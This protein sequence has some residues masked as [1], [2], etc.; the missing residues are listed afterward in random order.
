M[1]IPGMHYQ[2]ASWPK[3]KKW[4]WWALEAAVLDVRGGGQRRLACKRDFLDHK[5]ALGERAI[6]LLQQAQS[7]QPQPQQFGP[8][9]A[10]SWR[11]RP[12][13]EADACNCHGKSV[14]ELAQELLMALFG[15]Q[16]CTD[17]KYERLC[18]ALPEAAGPSAVDWGNFAHACQQ[19]LGELR[20]ALDVQGYK[21]QLGLDEAQGFA[22]PGR[23][24]RPGRPG[25][26]PAA[27]SEDQLR[28]LRCMDMALNR[29]RD[30]IDRW[31]PAGSAAAAGLAVVVDAQ[32]G[33]GP[34]VAAAHALP[35]HAQMALIL[36]RKVL[37]GVVPIEVGRIRRGVIRL[38]WLLRWSRHFDQG[39]G[40]GSAC[41]FGG[42]ARR[43]FG[44]KGEAAHGFPSWHALRKMRDA[45]GFLL[46]CERRVGQ[47][48]P[49]TPATPAG[50]QMLER[51]LRDAVAAYAGG[52]DDCTGISQVDAACAGECGEAAG[53][54]E[55][56]YACEKDDDDMD[57]DETQLLERFLQRLPL[58]LQVGVVMHRVRGP[59]PEAVRQWIRRQGFY[60]AFQLEESPRSLSPQ[61][62]ARCMPEPVTPD[63]FLQMVA[64]TADKAVEYM[65]SALSRLPRARGREEISP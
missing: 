44:R 53:H 28:R 15:E 59:V 5:Q 61:V 25:R 50:V 2:D 38:K 6:G 1:K 9:L 54:D 3:V 58:A 13:T 39:Q 11:R 24:Q 36:G 31:Q 34:A 41:L 23:R 32:G 33:A 62:L 20:D 52:E 64:G 51:V 37:P 56:D 22:A 16:A 10:E 55:E 40:A 65:R 49:C 45:L 63:A 42:Q 4:A 12:A 30:F 47:A 35:P 46:D 17:R 14:L 19:T 43:W 18:R 48:Q 26:K 21:V 29:F 27:M 60:E 57:V 8:L 7:L